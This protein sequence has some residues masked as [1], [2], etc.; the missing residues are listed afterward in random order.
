MLTLIN[1]YHGKNN[2]IPVMD[3]LLMNEQIIKSGMGYPTGVDPVVGDSY[4]T[5]NNKGEISAVSGKA[6][7]CK[8]QSG[9]DWICFDSTTVIAVNSEKAF[10][11]GFYGY[12]EFLKN[13]SSI[14]TSTLQKNW[15]LM[16][17]N[18]LDSVVAAT[19]EE[20]EEEE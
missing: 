2:S 5:V 1:D 12:R 17:G 16:N 18:P 10:N 19:L 15:S 14:P 13:N 4:N 6:V 11:A 3:S 8:K 20:E 9:F 7:T